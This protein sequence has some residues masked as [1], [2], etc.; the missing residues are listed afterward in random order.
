MFTTFDHGLC[1]RE[2]S[3]KHVVQDKVSNFCCY[4]SNV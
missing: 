2:K 1:E 4:I 3:G